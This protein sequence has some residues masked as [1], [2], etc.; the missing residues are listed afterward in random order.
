MISCNDFSSVCDKKLSR[1]C[2]SRPFDWYNDEDWTV[3]IEWLCQHNVKL[4]NAVLNP[5]ARLN[6]RLRFQGGISVGD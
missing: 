5:L 3:M 2:C 6:R 4:E 1:M